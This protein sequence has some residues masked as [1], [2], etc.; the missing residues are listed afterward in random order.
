MPKT[1]AELQAE[2]EAAAQREAEEKKAAEARSTQGLWDW[3]KSFL[4]DFSFFNILLFAAVVCGAY[5]FG[6]TEQ[7]QELLGKLFDKESVKNFFAKGDEMLAGAASAVG[8]NIDVSEYLAKMSIE[9]IRKTLTQ[10]D[11]PPKVIAVLAK[12]KP[13]FDAFITT[14]KEAN[15]GK[16]SINDLSIDAIVAGPSLAALLTPE[17]RALTVSLMAAAAPPE[18]GI[19]AETLNALISRN[20]AA[21][22]TP[23]P[24]LRKLLT[25]ATDGS[26]QTLQASLAGADGKFS[27]VKG[28]EALLNP[29]TRALIR[30]FGTGNI[31]LALRDKAPELSKELLD[32]A[33]TFGDAIDKN[34]ANGGANR[35]RTLAVLRAVA[36]MGE[37]VEAKEAFKGITAE[38]LSGFFQVPGNQEA[39][40]NLL[41]VVQPSVARHWGNPNEGIAEVLASKPD[42]DKILRFMRGETTWLEDLGGKAADWFGL[43]LETKLSYAGD[44]LA[45]NAPV[46]ANV[47]NGL[48]TGTKT[49]ARG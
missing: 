14:L 8:I 10:K 32:A 13:T 41:R 44:K 39:V 18:A 30:S 36:R 11:V 42:A 25:A 4:P 34:P 40:G 33:L 26:L 12:D 21:D 46:M 6:R 38:Q 7:G 24:E 5:F 49:N 20:V 23:T 19:K 43:S 15:G 29:Q 37:G 47:L 31:A 3:F 35:P 28:I 2:A 48:T 9:D 45:E 22:G 17:N 16:L 1:A 27:A